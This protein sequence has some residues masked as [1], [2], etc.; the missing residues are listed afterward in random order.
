M[1]SSTMTIN[2]IFAVPMDNVIA[3][4]TATNVDNAVVALAQTSGAGRA[5]ADNADAVI[6]SVNSMPLVITPQG[7]VT[8]AV[9]FPV[10]EEGNEIIVVVRDLMMTEH[11]ILMSDNETFDDLRLS[12]TRRSG[13]ESNNFYFMFKNRS[14]HMGLVGQ[15]KDACLPW[16]A[17]M[18]FY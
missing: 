4:H 17:H 16:T 10:A 9:G 14:F 6:T 12:Y 13:L 2:T 7:G 3:I 11:R 18:A 1:K 5:V 15:L 8:C